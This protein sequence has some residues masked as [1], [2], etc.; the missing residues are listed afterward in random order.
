MSGQSGY[1]DVQAL[2]PGSKTRHR[3]P[4]FELPDGSWVELPFSVVRGHKPG[5]VIYIGG[6]MHGDEPTSVAIAANVARD[7][8]QEEFSGTL[9]SVP[10]QSPL[11]FRIQHRLPIDQFFKSPMDQNPPDVFHAFPGDPQGNLASVV[12]HVLFTRLMA[13][14]EYVFD[15]HTPTTGGRY[16]PFVFLPPTR[17]GEIVGRCEEVAKVF[18]PDFILANDKGM[19]VGEKNPHVVAAE[20]GKVAFGIEVGEGGKLEPSEVARG[21]RGLRNIMRSLSMLPG[22]PEVFGKRQVIK[23]MTVVRSS[24]AGLLQ[25]AVDLHHEVSKGQVVATVT[26]LFGACV[27]E[28]IAPQDG[29]VVRITTFPTIPSNERVVQLG[30]NR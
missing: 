10:V 14:A 20:H 18:G 16:A 22:T 6:G 8:D 19:Y 5:P 29:P 17:C 21:V 13:Q 28:I 3:I 25:L 15:V 4:C 23:T 26:D 2:A 12:A 24:R 11:A 1:L 9:I 7:L 27:E 30:V